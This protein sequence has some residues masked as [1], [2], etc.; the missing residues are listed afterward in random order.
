ME[1][2]EQNI[3]KVKF[4]RKLGPKGGS[5]GTA[6]PPEL[7]DFLG[8][9]DGEEITMT[10]ETGKFGKFIALFKECKEWF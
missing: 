7:V 8:L 5:M 1:E 3:E 9:Q 10:A 2:M 4:T 6:I